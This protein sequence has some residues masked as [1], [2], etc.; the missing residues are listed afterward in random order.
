MWTCISLK[1]NKAVYIE[2]VIFGRLIR[3]IGIFKCRQTD[4]LRRACHLVRR[5]LL[6]LLNLLIYLLIDILDQVLQTHNTA[7]S[8][9]EWLTILTVHGTE[10]N[11][12]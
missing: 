1:G 9:L 8:G 3:K 12:L 11:V 6:L 5:N 10:T 2:N 7:I 4:N